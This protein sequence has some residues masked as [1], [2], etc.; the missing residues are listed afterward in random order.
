MTVPCPLPCLSASLPHFLLERL[1]EP[2]KLAAPPPFL[3]L[4][5]GRR[6]AG[7]GG[8]T[9]RGLLL[10]IAQEAKDGATSGHAA[11]VERRRHPRGV[12][13][14]EEDPSGP[15]GCGAGS[16][17]GGSRAREARSLRAARSSS[18][19]RTP[20]LPGPSSPGLPHHQSPLP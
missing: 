5:E 8:G 11:P 12:G 19:S 13:G 9:S 16:P 10:S 4:G 1:R 17:R 18:R 15:G 3:P 7:G 14:G 2:V 6:Q 20:S